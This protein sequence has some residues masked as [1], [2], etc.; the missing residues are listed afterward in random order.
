M[1]PRWPSP[2]GVAAEG[3]TRLSWSATFLGRP[4][5]YDGCTRHGVYVAM[6]CARLGSRLPMLLVD[7]AHAG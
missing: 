6:D 3:D 1:L 2:V 7:E 4:R 5:G